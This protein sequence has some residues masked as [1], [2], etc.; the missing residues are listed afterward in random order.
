[1]P[2]P[3]V[4]VSFVKALINRHRRTRHPNFPNN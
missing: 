4:F 1:M 3:Y 2:L